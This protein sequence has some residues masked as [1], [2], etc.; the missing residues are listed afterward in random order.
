MERLHL[1]CLFGV[2][3]L[4]AGC[5]RGLDAPLAQADLD[6]PY[7][8]C[9]AQPVLTKSCAAFACHG[10]ARRFFHV[11]ARNRLRLEGTES[12]RNAALSDRERAANFQAARAFVDEDGRGLLLEKPLEGA[13]HRGGEIF[14]RGNVFSSVEDEDYKTLAAWASGAKEDARCVE[15]GSDQ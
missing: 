13:F 10:D 4:V 14:G 6:E 7:F 2:L 5:Q 3:A 1:T 8:R 11:F 15:P 12:E 9:R